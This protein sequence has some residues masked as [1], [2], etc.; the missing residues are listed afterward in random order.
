MVY[1]HKSADFGTRMVRGFVRAG[2]MRTQGSRYVMHFSPYGDEPDRVSYNIKIPQGKRFVSR[3]L[4]RH[5]CMKRSDQRFELTDLRATLKILQQVKRSYGLQTAKEV[6]FLAA[7]LISGFKVVQ[8]E[9]SGAEEWLRRRGVM[10]ERNGRE[11]TI[12]DRLGEQTFTDDYYNT[13]LKHVLWEAIKGKG[14]IL[15]L[16]DARERLSVEKALGGA[17]DETMVEAIRSGRYFEISCHRFWG[18]KNLK[19]LRRL[20]LRSPLKISDYVT[21]ERVSIKEHSS[22]KNITENGW[23]ST[24]KKVLNN[25]FQPSEKEHYKG[26]MTKKEYRTLKRD[27]SRH[28]GCPQTRSSEDLAKWLESFLE[29]DYLLRSQGDGFVLSFLFKIT[30]DLLQSESSLGSSYCEALGEMG[31]LDIR[32]ESSG[33]VGRRKI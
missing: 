22:L 23:L 21:L 11:V 20:S 27:L 5:A 7:N 6:R 4:A 16:V 2:E 15:A 13:G 18:G 30:Q 8:D 14:L 3:M 17:D 32:S 24:I 1:A 33:G 25:Q 9:R 10:L 26:L 12:R 29:N 28:P 31:V 19:G